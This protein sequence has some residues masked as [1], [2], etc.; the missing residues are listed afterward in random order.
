MDVLV[1]WIL[2]DPTQENVSVTIDDGEDQYDINISIKIEVKTDVTAAEKKDKYK[3]MGKNHIGKNEDIGIVYDVKLIRTIGGV[4]ETIQ[5][6]DIKPGTH[7][8]V[9]MDI[10]EE[11]IAKSF[12]LLHFHDQN[13]ISEVTDYAI[14]ANGKTLYVVVDKLSEFIFVVPLSD[15]KANNGF[16]YGLAP[17]LIVIIVLGCLFGLCLLFL[18]LFIILLLIRK[19][20]KDKEEDQKKIKDPFARKNMKESDTLLS[21]S[22]ADKSKDQSV[23]QETQEEESDKTEE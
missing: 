23:T 21:S 20:D 2:V 6:S 8:T 11:L 12:R 4:Q 7:V 16:A 17:G 15:D 18:L 1:K 13:D 5:P 10:P 19:R 14:S 22:V 3:T 9:A